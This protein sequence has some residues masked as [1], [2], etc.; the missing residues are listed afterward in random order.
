MGKKPQKYEEEKSAPLV[1]I[2]E[3]EVAAAASLDDDLAHD[4][5]KR[6]DE[7]GPNPV[8]RPGLGLGLGLHPQRFPRDRIRSSE[9]RR[10][11]CGSSMH[12]LEGMGTS[13]S[14]PTLL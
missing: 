2:E 1:L 6:E 12:R 8:L 10:R 13:A 5:P 4:Q 7:V 9:R 14:T 3:P 11:A